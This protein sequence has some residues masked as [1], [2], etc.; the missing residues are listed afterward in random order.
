MKIKYSRDRIITS[1]TPSNRTKTLNFYPF[2]TSSLPAV[3]FKA[4]AKTEI[5]IAY[6]ERWI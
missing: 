2:N 1:E 5:R 4:F 3:C 6:C